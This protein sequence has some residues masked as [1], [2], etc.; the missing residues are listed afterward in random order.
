MPAL[1]VQGKNEAKLLSTNLV[2]DD[3]FGPQT[4]M[5]ELG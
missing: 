5:T 3:S 1:I 4:Q 2:R